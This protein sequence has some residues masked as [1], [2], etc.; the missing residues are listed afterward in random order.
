MCA[1][2]TSAAQLPILRDIFWIS[3]CRFG[4]ES[5]IMD[6]QY[7]LTRKYRFRQKSLIGLIIYSKHKDDE[8]I[9]PCRQRAISANLRY[10]YVLHSYKCTTFGITRE[11]GVSLQMPRFRR[12]DSFGRFANYHRNT[13]EAVAIHCSRMVIRRVVRTRDKPVA[14]LRGWGG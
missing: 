2:S 6:K 1:A 3:H 12:L 5:L 8:L 7:A 10:R 11:D 14:Y 9:E 4:C 13:L